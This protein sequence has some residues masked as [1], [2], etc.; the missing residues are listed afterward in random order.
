MARSK[1]AI[2]YPNWSFRYSVRK[3]GEKLWNAQF[4][5]S[6]DMRELGY[7]CRSIGYSGEDPK[8]VIMEFVDDMKEQVAII[9]VVKLT[10]S[11]MATFTTKIKR[12]TAPNTYLYNGTKFESYESAEQVMKSI[13]ESK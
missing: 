12:N 8:E 9:K 13:K 7:N 6:S 4:K 3:L 2:N 11:T 1:K 5:I 10:A